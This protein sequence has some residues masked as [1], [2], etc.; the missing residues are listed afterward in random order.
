MDMTPQI[1]V[2]ETENLNLSSNKE[3]V[4][5]YW[6]KNCEL[7]IGSGTILSNKILQ[8]KGS[9]HLH[10]IRFTGISGNVMLLFDPAGF[11]QELRLYPVNAKM[12]TYTYAPLIGMTSQ[13]DA[14]N[15]IIYYEYDGFSR[16]K[17]I[18]DENK[19]VLQQFDYKYQQAI[20]Q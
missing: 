20:N 5:T 12:T 3:Y 13:C 8:T 7:A 19:N 1:G 11:I 6:E 16:L 14:S 10:E 15:K 4:I 18:R 9:W 17:F 2:M